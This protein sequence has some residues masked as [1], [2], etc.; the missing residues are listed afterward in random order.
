MTL[1]AVL[2]FLHAKPIN[3]ISITGYGVAVRSHGSLLHVFLNTHPTCSRVHYVLS[4]H[5][6]AHESHEL[7][8][9]T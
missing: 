7:Q 6:S 4:I 3:K 9:A 1:L 5:A 8:P 2:H